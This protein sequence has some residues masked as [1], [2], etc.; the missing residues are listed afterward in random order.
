MGTSMPNCTCT[1]VCTGICMCVPSIAF[2]SV[3]VCLMAPLSVMVLGAAAVVVGVMECVLACV[4]ILVSAMRKAAVSGCIYSCTYFT[5]AS[6]TESV[7]VFIN[8][9]ACVLVLAGTELI[10]IMGACMVLCFGCVLTTVLV[11]QGCFTYC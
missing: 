1:C 11:A 7:C 10:F 4:T 6:A 9:G 2:G 3:P 8:N 5:A